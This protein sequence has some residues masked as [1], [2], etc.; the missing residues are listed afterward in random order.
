ME[1]RNKLKAL[2][3][4]LL[5][6]NNDNL[7]KVAID[8]VADS[9][10]FEAY[11]LEATANGMIPLMDEKDTQVIG[12]IHEEVTRLEQLSIPEQEQLNAQVSRSKAESV[13]QRFKLMGIKYLLPQNEND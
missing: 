7:K 6:K 4:K 3:A 1:F 13:A 10:K 11:C 8:R 12:W 2:E 5:P 9:K